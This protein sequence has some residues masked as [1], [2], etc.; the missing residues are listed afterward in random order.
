[1]A[2]LVGISEL[3]GFLRSLG[4]STLTKESDHYGLALTL[5]VGEIPLYELLRAYTV[6]SDRGKFCDFSP[7]PETEVSCVE[8]ADAKSV[9]KIE[10]VLTNRAFKLHE[11]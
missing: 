3:L 4:I 5:G 7:F 11:F 10:A 9:E 2:E 6:F 1:M 8:R